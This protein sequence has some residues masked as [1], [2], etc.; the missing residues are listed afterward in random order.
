MKHLKHSYLIDKKTFEALDD[1]CQKIS[2]MIT[3]LKKRL[4]L[5]V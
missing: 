2:A 1:R 3:N 5:N 4:T